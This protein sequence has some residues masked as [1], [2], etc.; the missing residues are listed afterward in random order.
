MGALEHLALDPTRFLSEIYGKKPDVTATSQDYSWLGSLDAFDHLINDT[1]LP[2]AAFRLVRDG[3]PIPTR[4]YTK[5]FGGQRDDAIKVA[6]P[7]LVFDHFG[8]G[9]TIVLEGMHRYSAPVRDLCRDLELELRQ[10]TQVNAYITP[11]GAQGFATHVDSHD[12]FV[13]QVFGTKHWLVHGH[14]DTDGTGAPVIERDLVAGDCLYIP[15]GFAHSATTGTSE[16]GHLTIGILPTTAKEMKRELMSMLHVS[17]GTVDIQ[18][19]DVASIGTGL[20]AEMRSQLDEVDEAGLSRRLTRLF[21][22]S[23]H[24]SLRGH[25]KRMLDA[26]AITD[27]DKVVS[28]V[29]WVRF[30]SDVGILVVLPDRELRFSCRL[31][32][33]L[34]VVLRDEPFRVAD[35]APHLDDDEERLAVV[36]RLIREG[37]LE[38]R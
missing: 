25:M 7:A 38:L 34:D 30:D 20:V 22:A 31:A 23:R 12:V 16:S 15:Q 10:G 21:F 6:D 13:V 32:P 5:K 33:A 2:A 19:G 35:L 17:A 24:H 37:L 9:A 29:E 11:K 36:A 27:S 1:L 26:A 8:E 3:K 4:T 18:D 28:R 14:D